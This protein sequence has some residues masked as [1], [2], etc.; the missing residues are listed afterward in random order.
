[1]DAFFNEGVDLGNI[2]RADTNRQAKLT[3]HTH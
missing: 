2:G 3:Q 1:M